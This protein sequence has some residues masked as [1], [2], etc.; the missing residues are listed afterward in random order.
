M[1]S[2][3]ISPPKRKGKGM[4]FS[5]EKK[6][7][8]VLY[9]RTGSEEK[10]I[11]RLKNTLDNSN[12]MPFLLQKE[13]IFRRQG[14]KSVF[15]KNCFPGYLFIESNKKAEDFIVYASQA[16]HQV[17]DAYRFLSYGDEQDIA[18]QE[19]EKIALK[20]IFGESYCIDISRG[21]KEGDSVKIVSGSLTGYESKITQINKNRGFAV[22]ALDILGKIVETAV[23]LEIIE[24]NY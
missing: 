14:R 11:R 4:P 6:Y 15:Q 17:D 22:I 1:C 16:I 5:N 21:F 20:A 19:N 24:K 12:Y 10:V 8:Y 18:M 9:T 23:G 13:C 2:L 7:W 3:F